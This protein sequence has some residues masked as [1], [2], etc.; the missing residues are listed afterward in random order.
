MSDKTEKKVLSSDG[1]HELSGWVYRPEGTPRG[2]FHVVH[3]MTEH[4]ARYD[5][6]MRDMAAAGYVCFGYDNLGHGHTVREASE[7]GFIAHREGFRYLS[8]DVA[9]FYAALREEYPGLPYYLMGHSMGSFIVR[10]AAAST[11]TPDKLVVMGT[12]G[13]NPAA[14]AGIALIRLIKATQGER[15]VSPFLEKMA[16]G[17]YNKGFE[18]TDPYRWLTRDEA[19]WARYAADP[20]CTFHFTASA[21]EDLVRL[22][23]MVNTKAWFRSMK[24]KMPILLVSGSEDPVGDHGKGVTAV[25]DGLTA[26]GAQV[27][28]ILYPGARHEIL[29][30]SCRGEVTADICRFLEK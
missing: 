17:E 22:N 9:R 30:D 18:G 24:E 23:R 16:F 19:V 27:Q 29:N 2:L 28:M 4:I 26:A 21:L 1:I 25:R 6:F 3:G 13:P 14:G 11:V 20:L 7:L 12:G 5:G 10:Q 15:A 8:E